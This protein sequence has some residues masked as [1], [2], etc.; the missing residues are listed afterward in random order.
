MC[1][2]KVFCFGHSFEMLYNI[3]LQNKYYSMFKR[4]FFLRYAYRRMVWKSGVHSC[5]PQLLW[6][7]Q[8]TTLNQIFF[9]RVRF[10]NFDY[11]IEN[12]VGI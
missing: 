5:G 10:A 12:V 7:D 8:L 9:F 11:V 4:I 1:L 3:T 2:V 6:M